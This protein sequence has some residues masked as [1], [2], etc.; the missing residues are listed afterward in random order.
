MSTIE[1]TQPKTGRVAMQENILD[2]YSVPAAMTAGGKY[3]AILEKL[4][5]DVGELCRI[6]QGLTIHEFVAQP[7]YG[8]DIPEE[9]KA[10]SHIRP[11]EQ[12][13][14]S[15]FA[16]DAR[17][18]TEARPPEKRLVGVCHH[19]VQFLLAMLRV[20]H[21][22]ARARW[23]FGAYFNPGFFEDHVVCETWNAREKRWTL[24]DPQ[25]DEVWKEKAKIEHNILDVPRDRFVIASDAWTLCRAGDEDPSKF[26]IIRGNLRGMWFIACNL[27]KDVAALNRLEMLPWDVWGAMPSQGEQF[28][29]EK[30]DFFS[31]LAVL[32]RSPDELFEE[33]RKLYDEDERVQVPPTVF[34]AVLNRPEKILSD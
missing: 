17:P 26:G 31:H 30:L 14:D 9:R 8:V 28:T 13:L 16:I 11:V 33:L 15:L 6:V 29:K 1:T 12:M 20:K 19:F 7:F 34:N 21:I 4:P 2:F 32:T 23:G 27:V 22:P 18:L 24:V 25:F 5:D 10:E 3:A